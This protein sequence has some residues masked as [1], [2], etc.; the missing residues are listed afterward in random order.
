MEKYIEIEVELKADTVSLNRKEYIKE[1]HAAN[2]E[3]VRTYKRNWNRKMRADPEYRK[4]DNAREK[5]RMRA[6]V[7]RNLYT[8]RQLWIHHYAKTVNVPCPIT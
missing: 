3:K 5:M 6:K 8:T 7:E 4:M 1:W 2:K